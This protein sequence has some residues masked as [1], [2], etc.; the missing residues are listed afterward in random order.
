MINANTE[1]LFFNWILKNP[2]YFKH[3]LGIYF[4]TEDIKFIYNCVRNEFLSSSDKVVP[5]KNEILTLVKM[6]DKENKI[7]PDY[8]KTL[9]KINWDDYRNE[10]VEPKFKSWVLSNSMINGL[11]DSIESVKG[12]DKTDII[13]VSEAIGKVKES[14]NNSTSIS[15]DKGNI[16][17]DF[18]DPNAH[19]QILDK[20]KISTGYELL[21]NMLDGGLDRKTLNLII[22]GSGTGKSLWANNLSVNVV[23]QG[24][25]VAYIT[26][27]LSDKKCLKRIGSMRLEIPINEYNE[28]SKDAEYMYNRI[29]EINKRNTN[30]VFETKPG[31]LFIKEYPSGS[32]TISDIENYLK[33]VKEEAN[34]DIDFLVVDYIQ[35]MGTEPGTDRNMLYLKGEHLAVGLRAIAQKNN[36]VLLT[37]AQV[38]KDKQGANDLTLSDVPESKAIFETADNVFGII[39]TAILKAENKYH[40]KWLKLRDSSTEYE[41]IGF[42]FN[43]PILRIH[44]NYQIENVL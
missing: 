44:S 2:Q 3:V 29:M 10:F 4:E 6:Y 32:C 30:G 27:E 15:L 39:L 41:R 42:L 8:I 21:D 38:A 11:V 43:R 16:G 22:G 35:I 7:E 18:D 34:I 36:L 37:M 14:I 25:N 31:K 28:R 9:L 17:L 23:N 5:S 40:L 26:L 12:L 13:K 33:Q 20:V 1:K 24:Y 19:D